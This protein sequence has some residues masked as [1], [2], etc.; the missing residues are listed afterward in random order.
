MREIF[1]NG[2]TAYNESSE[3]S[4]MWTNLNGERR[5]SNITEW[6]TVVNYDIIVRR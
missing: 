1:A 2:E 4:T 5:K 3:R 6:A